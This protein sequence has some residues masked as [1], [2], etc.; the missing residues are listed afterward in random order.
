[1]WGRF[2]FLVQPP[3]EV[4][5]LLK[6]LSSGTETPDLRWVGC[7]GVDFGE[8]AF[9]CISL[10]GSELLM[11]PWNN[12]RDRGPAGWIFLPP[13]LDSQPLHLWLFSGYRRRQWGSW[14]FISCSI[15]GRFS[16]FGWGYVS[17]LF[18]VRLGMWEGTR[19]L[20]GLCRGLRPWANCGKVTNMAVLPAG[21]FL[22][23]N[24]NW[25]PVPFQTQPVGNEVEGLTVQH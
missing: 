19:V 14:R 4:Q 17:L 10:C 22:A 2:T 15:Q 5:Q 8:V 1:M 16:N 7:L 13:F 24:N 11:S 3:P 18:V 25:Q 6:L 12:F 9:F 23:R 21:W 20:V